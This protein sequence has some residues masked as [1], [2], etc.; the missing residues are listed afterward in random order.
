MPAVKVAGS[1]GNSYGQTLSVGCLKLFDMIFPDASCV[2]VAE[3]AVNTTVQ[4]L[5]QKSAVAIKDLW[6]AQSSKISTVVVRGS[7]DKVPVA[8]ECMRSP[9][10]SPTA[11][12]PPAF[13]FCN[14]EESDFRKKVFVAPVSWMGVFWLSVCV[15]EL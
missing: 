8:T 15:V 14:K 7:V 4:P 10:G 1:L 3:V 11:I 5:L 6:R 13:K 2:T 9:L 12:P